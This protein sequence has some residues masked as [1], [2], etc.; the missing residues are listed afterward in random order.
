MKEN[1]FLSIK[2][3]SFLQIFPRSQCWKRPYIL[4][5][6]VVQK[7]VPG[8]VIILGHILVGQVLIDTI[9]LGHIIVIDQVGTVNDP[10]LIIVL[11]VILLLCIHIDIIHCHIIHTVP[12]MTFARNLNSRSLSLWG[13]QWKYHQLSRCKLN[14]WLRN[15]ILS[16]VMQTVSLM[17]FND[18]LL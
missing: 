18:I 13:T 15:M 10:D 7:L 1:S 4:G 14:N 17:L 5:L 6:E 2:N 3:R 9:V 12:L 8:H 16:I 11:I